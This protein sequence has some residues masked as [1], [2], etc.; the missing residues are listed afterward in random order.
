MTTKRKKASARKVLTQAVPGLPRLSDAVHYVLQKGM[1]RAGTVGRVNS[2]G[3]IDLA[4]L[5]FKSPP[6]R[7]EF[8]FGVEYDPIGK[9]QHTWHFPSE[10]A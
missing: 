8:A 6:P 10:D 9:G 1:E 3:T 2:D 5:E 7:T 4:Y